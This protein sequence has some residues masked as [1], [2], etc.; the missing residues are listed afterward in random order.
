MKRIAVLVSIMIFVPFLCHAHDHALL[1]TKGDVVGGYNFYPS[2]SL[3]YNLYVSQNNGIAESGVLSF[4]TE[5]IRADWGGDSLSFEYALADGFSIGAKT[6]ALQFLVGGI[7][8]GIWVMEGTLFS[9]LNLYPLIWGKQ[10]SPAFLAFW[11]LE[12]QLAPVYTSAPA[13]ADGL[14]NIFSTLSGDLRIIDNK[15]FVLSSYLELKTISSFLHPY[16]KGGWATPQ[17]YAD[18]F[19]AYN[20]TPANDFSLALI[21]TTRIVTALGFD[22][23]AIEHFQFFA[24]I[25]IPIGTFIA[26]SNKVVK[27]SSS[28]LSFNELFSSTYLEFELKY[29]F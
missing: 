10:Q 7:R 3:I 29:K 28:T 22:I 6:N 12:A 15:S 20:L 25:N 9:S 19:R 8:D 13:Y 11:N 24:G 26:D 4:G 23:L 17:Y 5:E 21:P 18:F 1:L 27:F 2:S 16:Y 14:L